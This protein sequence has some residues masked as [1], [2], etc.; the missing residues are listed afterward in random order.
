[1]YPI[2]IVYNRLRFD[3]LKIFVHYPVPNTKNKGIKLNASGVHKFFLYNVKPKSFT[4]TLFIYL[5]F[6]FLTPICVC[7]S[8]LL[9]FIHGLCIMRYASHSI[10][11]V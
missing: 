1:M 10:F 3:L 5:F 7:V 11:Q 8:V 6:P 4:N 9:A 2:Q